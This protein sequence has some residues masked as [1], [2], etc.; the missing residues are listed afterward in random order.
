MAAWVYLM[1]RRNADNT[2]GVMGAVTPGLQ[3]SEHARDADVLARCGEE[4]WELAAVLAGSD[5]SLTYYFKRAE[6]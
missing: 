6:E 3:F 4:G 1:V 2:W 5:S